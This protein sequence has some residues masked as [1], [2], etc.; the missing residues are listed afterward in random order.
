MAI[1]E[2]WH[3][4]EQKDRGGRGVQEEEKRGEREREGKNRKGGMVSEIKWWN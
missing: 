4:R 1:V 2:G 3:R